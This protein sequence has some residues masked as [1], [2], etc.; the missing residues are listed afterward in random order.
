MDKLSGN[1]FIEMLLTA[2]YYL[3]ENQKAVDDL[4]VFPV[5]DGDTGSNMLSTVL[6]GIRK[7]QELDE[8]PKIADV[9]LSFSRGLLFGARGN[10]GVIL[11]QIFSGLATVDSNVSD[12]TID[13]IV[14]AFSQS[15]INAYKS[16]LVPVEGTILTV[17]SDAT[18]AIVDNKDKLISIEELA[19]IYVAEAIESLNRTP[20]LLPI[21]KEAGVVDSGGAGFVYLCKGMLAALKGETHTFEEVL[22]QSD[23][24]E[25]G[26]KSYMDFDYYELNQYGYCTEFTIRLNPNLEFDKQSFTTKLELFGYSIV[27]VNNDDIVKVHIH[28][29]TPGD[30]FSFAQKYGALCAVKADNMAIQTAENSSLVA[31]KVRKPLKKKK[32]RSKYGVV[33]TL[34][35]DGLKEMFYALGVDEIIDGGQ[36]MNPSTQDFIDAIDKVNAEHVF[37]IPNNKNVYMSAKAAKALIN[38]KHVIVIPAKTISQG[39]AAMMCYDQSE[40]PRA[41]AK[42]METKIASVKSGEITYAIR[43]SI[44]NGVQIKKN[45]FISILDGSII[46]SN[47]ERIDSLNVLLK[48]MITPDSTMITVFYGEDVDTTE[49]E[50]LEAFVSDYPDVCLQVLNGGQKIY[51]YIIEVE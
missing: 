17:V 21:L 24:K 7:I 12:A 25:V 37:V 3:K 9:A 16:V 28:T 35:G 22:N 19:E 34:N 26:Q 39:Y 44:S 47:K 13:V 38:D 48:K 18:K 4:N 32:E 14:N 10:S 46:T 15:K 11:S 23:K 5:P 45:D 29:K 41:I 20:L 50:K 27:V 49:I 33:A 1:K 43:D 31:Q 42:D 51:S 8:N 40:S 30:V 36:T 2:A 6:S